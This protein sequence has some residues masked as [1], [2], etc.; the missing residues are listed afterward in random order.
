L[1]P[2]PEGT[3]DT[4]DGFYDPEKGTIFSYDNKILRIPHEDE[5]KLFVTYRNNGSN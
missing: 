3:Y 4:G 5:V 1:K 2:I